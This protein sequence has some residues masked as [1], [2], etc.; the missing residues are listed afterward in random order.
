MCEIKMAYNNFS[1]ST[2]TFLQNTSFN[3]GN[4]CNQYCDLQNLNNFFSTKNRLTVLHANMRSLGKN[5]SKLEELIAELNKSPDIVAV[6]ETWLSDFKVN[7]V[8]IDGY[9]FI[10]VNAK[11]AAAGGMGHAGGVGL[12]LKNSITYS[13]IKTLGNNLP[14]AESLWVELNLAKN[15][16]IILGVI[17]RHP[18]QNIDGFV[19]EVSNCLDKLNKLKK[20]YYICGDINIDFLNYNKSNEIK[21]YYDSL[22]SYGCMSLLNC[23]TR[24]TDSSSTLIDHL[25][26]ND[27]HHNINCKILIHDISD[28]FPFIFSVNANSPSNNVEM[29]RK[30]NMKLFKYEDFLQDLSLAFDRSV[31]ENEHTNIHVA[32][33]SFVDT[34]H[35]TLDKHAP[36]RNLTRREKKLRRKPWIT[37]PILEII[38]VKNELYALKIKSPENKSIQAQYKNCRNKLTHLKEISKKKYYQEMIVNN[39]HNSSKIW[40][41]INDIV[42][43]KRNQINNLPTFFVNDD[44]SVLKDPIDI[45][46]CFNNYFSYIGPKLAAKIPPTN[47]SATI[48]IPQ[49]S[50]S[51]FLKP[52][53]EQ[54]VIYKLRNLKDSKSSGV[55]HIPNKIIKL[56]NSI[57]APILTKLY[58]NSIKQGI[59]PDI[60]KVAQIVPIFKSGSKHKICNYR[61]ISIL[62]SFTKIFEKCLYEQISSYL[63]EKS[64][65]I[66]QQFGFRPNYS[67]SIALNDICNELLHNTEKKKISCTVFLDLAKAFDT[68]DHCILLKKLEIYGIRGLPLQLL[69]SYLLNRKQQTVFK[70]ILSKFNPV[71]CGV[72]QGSTLGPLLFLIYIN[73]LPLHTNF[74]VRLFADDTN[75]T[76]ASN[77]LAELQNLVNTEMSKIDQWMNSNKLSINSS[78]SQYMLVTNKKNTRNKTFQLMVN[79][80]EIKQ[81]NCIKYLGVLIDDKLSWKN[82]IDNICSK[83]SRGCWAL[84]NLKSYLPHRFLVDVYYSLIYSHLSYCITSWGCAANTNLKSLTNL[85]KRAI[86]IVADK[87]FRE[88]TNPLFIKLKLLKIPQI[89]KLELSKLMYKVHSNTITISDS[90]TFTPVSAVHHYQTRYGNDNYYRKQI[91]KKFMKKSV[92]ISGP[93]AWSEVPSDIKRFSYFKF[94][95]ALKEH[96][97]NIYRTGVG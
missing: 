25:Y 54:D 87:S 92:E 28:H 52:I 61:P 2:P 90:T 51:F 10:N 66:P 16:Q 34:L 43:Y 26:S 64:I 68:I 35:N 49:I 82:H 70:G 6:S 89:Y 11:N 27:M 18:R 4:S 13:E 73:D 69:Q 17:Y 23:P 15:K 91:S 71:T 79:N 37:Q 94:K 40:K 9:Q 44:N 24:V 21:Q 83:I 56:C 36:L 33:K 80:S 29:L 86:R 97:L 75:L 58:N 85:Q 57:I 65:L 46:N 38:K 20:T 93:S 45:S 59:F 96:F 41:T 14:N 3:N 60:L 74:K 53:L 88:H 5:F 8:L 32:F 42:R 76:L 72:P 50:S 30:R 12:Y 22:C 48:Q 39:M 67:T 31:I 47:I 19:R 77:N 84:Q 81:S 1:C 55:N 95:K 62:P 63:T 78:K 7:K